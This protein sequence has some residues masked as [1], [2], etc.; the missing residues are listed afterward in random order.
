MVTLHFIKA[1]FEKGEVVIGVQIEGP[2][3]S[4]IRF[5]SLRLKPTDLGPKVMRQMLI[6]RSEMEEIAPEDEAMF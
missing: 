3:S 1:Y 6:A 4:W 5:G 2:K